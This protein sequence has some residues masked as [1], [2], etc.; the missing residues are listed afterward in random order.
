M[1]V[2]NGLYAMLPERDG[3]FLEQRAPGVFGEATRTD[4]IE[5]TAAHDDLAEAIATPLPPE[6]EDELLL[7]PAPTDLLQ[8]A[9][10]DLLQPAPID[11]EGPWRR[12][13][14]CATVNGSRACVDVAVITLNWYLLLYSIEARFLVLPAGLSKAAAF[15]RRHHLDILLLVFIILIVVI[16]KHFWYYYG[17]HL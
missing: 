3:V 5:Y 16:L 4:P 10:T 15:A 17:Q 13:S 11:Y 12:S 7:P 8:P 1:R 14:V 2:P 9:P 6:T